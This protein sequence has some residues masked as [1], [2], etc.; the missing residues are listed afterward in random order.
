MLDYDIHKKGYV[1]SVE[2]GGMVDGPGIRYVVFLAGCTLRCKYCHNPD[3]WKISDDQ[4]V[5][6]GDVIR[7]IKKYS[8]YLKFSG[9][10][11]TITGGE[12]LGQPDFLI[13][14]LK[15]CKA[16][17]LHTVLD[18]SGHGA[19]GVAERALKY[20]DLLLLDIKTIN[21]AVY[22]NLTGGS[23]ERTLEVLKLSEIHKVPVWV[24]FVLVPGYTDDFDDIQ[25]LSDFLKSYKNIE[26]IEVL[27]FHKMG[28]YKWANMDIPYELADVEPPSM[29]ALE[30]AKSILESDNSSFETEAEEA[31]VHMIF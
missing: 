3:T 7:D 31:S 16:N 1:H 23:L 15:A 18:T 28:E 9:G 2:T 4:S 22:K 12:P 13:E 20:T 27:P 30:R 25:K 8:S 21:P 29:E 24:R 6:L 19:P 14:L 26:K 11:V 5:L 10:G 17:A